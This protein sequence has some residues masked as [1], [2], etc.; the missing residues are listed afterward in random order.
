MSQAVP[1]LE[2]VRAQRDADLEAMIA[3]RTLADPGRRPPPLENLRH[4]LDSS[5]ALTYYVALLDGEPAGCGFVDPGQGE[6]AQAH[7]VVVP[8][9]RCRGIGSELLAALG[10]H[11]N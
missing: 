8:A 2:V 7:C 1:G 4:N 3:V 9:L 11:A 10:S 6:V 5:E